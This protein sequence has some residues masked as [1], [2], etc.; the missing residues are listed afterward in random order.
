MAEAQ[1]VRGFVRRHRALVAA[2]AVVAV[3][4]AAFVLVYFQPQKAFLD[5]RVNEALPPAGQP[6]QSGGWPGPAMVAGGD[7]RS[8]EHETTGHAVIVEL[9]DGSRLLR[10]ENLNTLNGPDLHVYLS[11]VPA[12]D[13]A[14]AYGGAGY[15]DLGRLKGN[16]GSQNY[17]LPKDLDLS[18]FRSAVIWCKR[19]SVGFGVA[20][21]ET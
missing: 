4:L 6:A 8:L 14:R 20:P 9:A 19:F 5:Q 21:L 15:V 3:A 1:G 12:G 10:F 11:P 16:I 7:F 17:P 18:K 13:D 2:A